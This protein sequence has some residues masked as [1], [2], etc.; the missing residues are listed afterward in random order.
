VGYLNSFPILTMHKNYSWPNTRLPALSLTDSHKTISLW[1]RSLPSKA[2]AN[3]RDSPLRR[4]EQSLSRR[5]QGKV[6]KELVELTPIRRKRRNKLRVRCHWKALKG[7]KPWLDLPLCSKVCD[8]FA[9]HVRMKRCYDWFLHG[10]MG[11]FSHDGDFSW[12]ILTI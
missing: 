12:V 7:E 4:A 5:A 3:R 10:I 8:L 1:G 9:G 11:D 2:A 6:P